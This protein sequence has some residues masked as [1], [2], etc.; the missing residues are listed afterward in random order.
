M[1]IAIN[2]LPTSELAEQQLKKVNSTTCENVSFT[3]RKDKQ[4]DKKDKQVSRDFSCK[5]CN[6]KHEFGKR[7]CPAWGK[8][9]KLCK[10]KNHFESSLVCE[11]SKKQKASNK[12]NLTNFTE[13]NDYSSDESLSTA[14]QYVNRVGKPGQPIVSLSDQKDISGKRVSV[15][16]LIDTGSTCNIMP[17]D[18]LQNIVKNPILQKT[19]SQLKLYDVATMKSIGKYNLYAKIKGKFFKLPFEIVSTKYL[20]IRCYQQILVKS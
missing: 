2:C 13:S 6:K 15:K 20:E 19:E 18:I 16:C 11:E 10:I 17:F 1:N 7:F 12:T 3:K 14:T 9:C 4:R 8:E 5:L